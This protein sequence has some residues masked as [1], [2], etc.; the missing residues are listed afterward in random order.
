MTDHNFENRALQILNLVAY[1]YLH[2]SLLFIFRTSNPL[3]KQ[4]IKNI[5][6]EKKKS[7]DEAQNFPFEKIKRN[8][9]RLNKHQNAKNRIILASKL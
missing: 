7:T 3:Q 8:Y 1:Y 2:N 5:F 6:F 9:L 4:K